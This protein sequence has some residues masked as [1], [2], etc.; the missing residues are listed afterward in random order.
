M[1]R[2]QAAA[3]IDDIRVLAAQAQAVAELPAGQVHAGILDN[4]LELLERAGLK[5]LE[6]CGG[7][8]HSNPFIDNCMRCA[9]R[10]GWLGGKEVVS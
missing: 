10:W 2:K 4:L 5:P 8:A 1:R 6:P 3:L 7:E 9:P